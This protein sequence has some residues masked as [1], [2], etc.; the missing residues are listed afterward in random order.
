MQSRGTRGS[1]DGRAKENEVEAAR[2]D[3][4]GVGRTLGDRGADPRRF[5]ARQERGTPARVYSSRLLG[6]VA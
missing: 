2:D 6:N 4:A 5:L 1:K 3:L